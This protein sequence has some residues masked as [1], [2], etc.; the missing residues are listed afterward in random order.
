[1]KIEYGYEDQVGLGHYYNVC[2]EGCLANFE[3]G[4]DEEEASKLYPEVNYTTAED[5]LKRYV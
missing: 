5:Y 2:Y 3:I 4:E 1:M